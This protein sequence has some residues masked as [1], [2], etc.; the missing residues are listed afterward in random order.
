MLRR[1]LS[2]NFAKLSTPL[3]L[4]A[5]LVLTACPQKTPEDRVLDARSKYTVRLNTFMAQEP[6][7]EPILEGDVD[8]AGYASG[9]AEVVAVAAEAV[10]EE[11]VA[12]EEAAEG[13]EGEEAEVVETGPSSTDI[14]FDL[15]IQFDGPESLP[16][17]TVEIT[18]ADP[19]EQEKGSLLHYVETGK[20]VKSETRQESFT[21]P[22]ENFE[23]GDVFS[24]ELRSLVPA[25]ERGNYREF[26]EHGFE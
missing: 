7:P 11:A 18:H 23:E 1:I 15:I 10:A 12:A 26:A 16:G 5:A 17:I 4:A 13:E 24:V 25:E 20:M 8:P 19:F 2:L 21:L 22:I 6:E 9:E 14:F 3:L